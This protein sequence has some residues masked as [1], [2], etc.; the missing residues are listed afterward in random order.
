TGGI[1]YRGTVLTG[2]T[3]TYF[4]SD[5]CSGRLWGATRN[6]GGAAWSAGQLLATGM[7][8]TTFGEDENGEIYLSN[9]Q[10]LYKLVPG[11]ATPRLTITAIGNGTG[12]VTSSP[13]ALECGSICASH[14]SSGTIVT[15]TATPDSGWAFRGWG[16]DPDCADGAV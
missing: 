1:S 13:V 10:Q 4:F 6:P 2:H 14:F 11:S 12:R 3:G 7:N 8:I 16:G 15:L 5:F 9:Y